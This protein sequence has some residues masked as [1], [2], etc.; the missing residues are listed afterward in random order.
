MG[1]GAQITLSSAD[2]PGTC[3]NQESDQELPALCLLQ[4]DCA[5]TEM[6]DQNE[7]EKSNRFTCYIKLAVDYKGISLG[8]QI[9]YSLAYTCACF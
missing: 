9:C 1:Q 3:I 7:E 6:K 8:S 4:N 5:I 2:P